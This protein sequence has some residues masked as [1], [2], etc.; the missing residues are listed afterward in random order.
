MNGW[1]IRFDRAIDIDEWAEDKPLEVIAGLH[2]WLTACSDSGPPADSWL[3]ELE[4][5]YRFRY[6]IVDVNVT[7]EFIAVMHERFM[8]VKKLD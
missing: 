2:S 5:G 8:L 3:V 7:V 1:T 6:W 4:D